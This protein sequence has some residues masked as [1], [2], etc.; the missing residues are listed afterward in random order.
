MKHNRSRPDLID[1]DRV[2]KIRGS[3][4]QIE[5]RFI[6]G[7]Y[8]QNI[9]DVKKLFYISENKPELVDMVISDLTNEDTETI[10]EDIIDENEEVDRPQ[11]NRAVEILNFYTLEED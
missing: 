7:R 11:F 2:R 4:S 3:F 5:H 8:I 1:S 9:E 10:A 6:N